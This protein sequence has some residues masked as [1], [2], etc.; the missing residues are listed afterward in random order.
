MT[1]VGSAVLQC[2]IMQVAV[3]KLLAQRFQE[4][5]DITLLRLN[6]SK[7]FPQNLP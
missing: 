6:I 7:M 1:G 4:K 5:A 3:V 2:G